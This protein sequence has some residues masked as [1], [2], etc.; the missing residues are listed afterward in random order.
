MVWGTN[1]KKN[2]FKKIWVLK[3]A[4]VYNPTIVAVCYTENVRKG[5]FKAFII[6]ISVIIV[7]SNIII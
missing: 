4:Y 3:K 6:T 7:N 5:P 1:G 2:F